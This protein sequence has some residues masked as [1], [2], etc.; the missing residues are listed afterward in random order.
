VRSI[1]LEDENLLKKWTINAED[2]MERELAKLEIYP[3]ERGE[4]GS[5][6]LGQGAYNTVIDVVYKGKRAATRYSEQHSELKKFLEFVSYKGKLPPKFA[7][8]FPKV[9]KVFDFKLGR[10]TIF[11]V[12]VELLDK[13]PPGLYHDLDS[14]Y[15][16]VRKTRLVPLKDRKVIVALAKESSPNN[17]DEQADM[18]STFTK[19]IA[20]HL[21][22]LLGKPSDSYDEL[23]DRVLGPKIASSKFYRYFYDKLLYAIQGTVIP[24]SGSE[25]QMG[26]GTIAQHY[27]SKKVRDFHKFLLALKAAGLPWSDLH[28]DNFMMRR[29]TEDLV[30]VDPG[31]FGGDEPDF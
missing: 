14:G 27:P 20:P 26:S 13:L 8:H 28:A 22:A 3:I 17:T 25:Y 29:D 15:D 7:K 2:N 24:Q 6:K 30:V 11:G 18:V 4:K 31:L 23:L 21:D 19:E 1:L 12:V 5:I 9:Y 16:I 10:K